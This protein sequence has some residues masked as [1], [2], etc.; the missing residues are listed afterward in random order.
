MIKLLQ[1]ILLYFSIHVYSYLGTAKGT[2]QWLCQNAAR[3]ARHLYSYINIWDL[4]LLNLHLLKAWNSCNMTQ[5]N[6][7]GAHGRRVH[8]WLESHNGTLDVDCS[9]KQRRQRWNDTALDGGSITAVGE[10]RD[11]TV[12]QGCDGG[13]GEKKASREWYI[14]GAE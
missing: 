9:R 3:H 2:D 1:H 13:T 6:C 7:N 14:R 11:I 4:H 5:Q 12:G 10:G 8:L